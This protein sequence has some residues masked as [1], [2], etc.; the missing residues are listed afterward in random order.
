MPKRKQPKIVL[1]E[2]TAKQIIAIC[3]REYLYI[4]STAHRAGE[5]HTGYSKIRM[6]IEDALLRQT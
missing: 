5:G 3:R 6:I 2:E 4:T 1:D